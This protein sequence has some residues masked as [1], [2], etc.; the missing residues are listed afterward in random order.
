MTEQG[1]AAIPRWLL[2]DSSV[3]AHA[4]IVYLHLSS[5]MDREHSCYPSQNLLARES[6]ISV[7]SVKRALAE[8]ENL[9][10]ITKRAER[11]ATGRRNFYR[12]LVHP[13]DR[14]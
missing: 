9:G 12:I 3:S 8:L 14:G 1:W 2:H 10:I 11:T 13:T 7:S 4:K 5:R 6:S